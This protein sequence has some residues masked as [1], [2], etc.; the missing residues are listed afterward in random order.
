MGEEVPVVACRSLRGSYRRPLGGLWRPFE[1]AT[2]VVTL[3]LETDETLLTRYNRLILMKWVDERRK[4]V[5]GDGANTVSVWDVKCNKKWRFQMP[6][7]LGLNTYQTEVY[8]VPALGEAGAMLSSDGD[9]K[10]RC[11][12]L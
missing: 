3:K 4:L 7:G 5:V 10:V 9:W 6:E 1:S 11:W 2:A 8:F 12:D